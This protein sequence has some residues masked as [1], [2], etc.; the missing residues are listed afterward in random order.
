LSPQPRIAAIDALRGFALIGIYF[1]NI[2]VMGGPI[3]TESPSAT[4]SFSNPDWQIWWVD[5][6]FVRGAMRGLFSILFGASTLLFLR[7]KARA[8]AYVRR[9]VWLFLFGV[10]NA[11]L[12]L[13]PGDILVIYALAGPVILLF[14]DAKP[15]TLLVAAALTTAV[16][17]AWQYHDALGPA[18]FG[19]SDLTAEHDARLGNY[20]MNLAFMWHKSLEWTI[21]ISTFRWLLDAVAFMLI[22]MALYR[23]GVLNGQAGAQTYALMA[24][25][26]FA[27]G[28]PLRIWQG[29]TAFANDGGYS[30]L[31][32]GT[33]QMGRLLITFGWLGAFM[34]VW[35]SASGAGLFAPLSALGRMALTGYLAQSAAAALIF[36]GSG[37]GLWNALGWPGRWLIVPIV[38]T[39][40]AIFSM[41][42]LNRFTMGPMEWIWRALTFGAV[43]ELRKEQLA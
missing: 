12:L 21:S 18:V 42:W 22:G 16:L 25:L 9:C 35:K 8:G 24:T 29:W 15:T 13:W 40:L 23:L 27:I 20:A 38:M 32:E 3:D 2:L 36:S 17:S 4:A 37:L 14:R 30:A 6:L 26:G 1:F 39:V 10:V 19:P 5:S 31:A 33:F 28:V 11:T 41:A 7:Q 34:L 43:P